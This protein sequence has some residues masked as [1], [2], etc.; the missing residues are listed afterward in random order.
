MKF[1]GNWDAASQKPTTS[2]DALVTSYRC[3][4]GSAP[5]PKRRAFYRTTRS[6]KAANNRGIFVWEKIF[7]FLVL[8]AAAALLLVSLGGCAGVRVRAAADSCPA[9]PIM[10][11]IDVSADGVIANPDDVVENHIRLWDHIHAIRSR[12]PCPTK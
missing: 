1:N 9:M 10:L 2:D 8:A 12:V 5:T 3:A 4:G 7:L 11:K 6:R